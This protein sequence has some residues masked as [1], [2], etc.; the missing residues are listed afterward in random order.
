MIEI[1]ILRR[2]EIGL[3]G[4]AP[5]REVDVARHPAKKSAILSRIWLLSAFVD[6]CDAV[7]PLCLSAG[8]R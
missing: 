8:E 1:A 7:F 3:I 4:R 2:Q 5:L 6:Y